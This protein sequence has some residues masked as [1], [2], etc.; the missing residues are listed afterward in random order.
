MLEIKEGSLFP[1]AMNLSTAEV[2]CA[3]EASVGVGAS[4]SL[5]PGSGSSPLAQRK[6]LGS[7][8]HCSGMSGEA[9]ICLPS[10]FGGSLKHFKYACCSSLNL[11]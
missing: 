5:T 6:L 10:T 3:M 9:V 8:A 7:T 11:V 1:A 4:A 2:L